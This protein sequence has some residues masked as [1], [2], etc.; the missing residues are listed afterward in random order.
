MILEFEN[1]TFGY[2][3]RLILENISFSIPKGGI[4][5]IIGPSGC[6]KSTLFRLINGLEKAQS[7]RILYQGRPIEGQ[8]GI[9]AFM[10]QRDLLM[11][12]RT[13]LKNVTLA[14]EL[15]KRRDG[16]QAAYELLE[17]VGLKGYENVYPSELSGGM[18]QRVSFARTLA[19]GGELMLL[20]EPF[21]ALDSL[22]RANM[23]DWLVSQM[24]QLDKTV[25]LVTHDID[26]AML[27]GDR[28]LL[29]KGSP[30]GGMLSADVSQIAVREDIYKAAKLRTELLDALENGGER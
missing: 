17:R 12:W 27:L 21:S 10:P 14:F 11:P 20:D 16:K 5:A 2:G 18:R 22:T 24:K 8:K 1:V 28:V 4:T 15:K 13:A 6:G 25:L 19:V 3:D 9:A 7:G 30:V 26:E 29:M 23:Q